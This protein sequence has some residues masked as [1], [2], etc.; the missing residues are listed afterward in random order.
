V[1][2]IRIDA[3]PVDIGLRGG[4][5][6]LAVSTRMAVTRRSSEAG[7]IQAAPALGEPGLRWFSTQR[8]D[9]AIEGVGPS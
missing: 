9:V 5:P 2:V 1:D 6:G 4:G 7:K 8:R 3:I